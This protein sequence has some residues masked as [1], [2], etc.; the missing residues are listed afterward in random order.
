MI[1]HRPV[2]VAITLG[3]GGA[4]DDDIHLGHT[5]LL[6]YGVD[7][8]EV[9][10]AGHTDAGDVD[11]G[12]GE[13]GH[14]EGVADH[15]H[16]R[17]VDNHIVVIPAG[18]LEEILEARLKQQFGGVWGYDAGDYHIQPFHLLDM[19]HHVTE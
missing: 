3:G 11:C 15:A 14:R 12:V 8:I 5:V 1:L 9:A 7:E 19:L 16:R 2:A 4:V 10:E 18:L 6:V 13:V 17:G